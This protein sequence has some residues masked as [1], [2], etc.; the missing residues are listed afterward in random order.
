MSEQV[1]WLKVGSP[2][3]RFA[4]AEVEERRARE[5]HRPVRTAVPG[6]AVSERQPQY[7]NIMIIFSG[8]VATIQHIFTDREGESMC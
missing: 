1:T 8:G 6:G 2:N 3:L 4:G 7:M 5:R